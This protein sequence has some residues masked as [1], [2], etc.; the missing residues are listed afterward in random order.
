MTMH[1]PRLPRAPVA[2]VQLL[3]CGLRKP[4]WRPAAPLQ[5]CLPPAPVLA[6]ALELELE[7]LAGAVLL[8]VV[9]RRGEGSHGNRDR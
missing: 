5:T 3:G 7:E 4:R 9:G 6:L 8:V 1:Q 2:E